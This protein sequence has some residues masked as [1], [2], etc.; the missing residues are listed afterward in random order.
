MIIPSL[1]QESQNPEKWYIKVK[2]EGPEQKKLIQEQL[3]CLFFLK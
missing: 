3:F 2:R 1:S